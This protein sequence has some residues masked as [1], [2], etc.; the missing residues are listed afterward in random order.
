MSLDTV[1]RNRIFSNPNEWSWDG[2]RFLK[3]PGVTLCRSVIDNR[4]T[5]CVG[6]QLG[7]VKLSR[8]TH[9][10]IEMA[11]LLKSI[12]DLKETAYGTSSRK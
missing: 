7:Y 12:P 1:I 2:P 8:L 5:F 11:R 9:A 10:C 3:A 6:E 4:W